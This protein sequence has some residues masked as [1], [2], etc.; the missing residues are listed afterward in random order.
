MVQISEDWDLE[1]GH[2]D[3]PQAPRHPR[4]HPATFLHI[5]ARDT[6]LG[7]PGRATWAPGRFGP[8][9]D[10]SGVWQVSAKTSIRRETPG[11]TPDVLPGL[12]DEAVASPR[13]DNKCEI[14]HTSIATAGPGQAG[15]GP[16]RSRTVR[17]GPRRSRAAFRALARWPPAARGTV[18]APPWLRRGVEVLRVPAPSPS[19]R[20]QSTAPSALT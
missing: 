1:V 15:R 14:T 2:R 3:P 11:G 10:W 20:R 13:H 7:W 18:S 5:P 6:G 19:A 17:P 9:L 12:D 16:T 8:G 4:R